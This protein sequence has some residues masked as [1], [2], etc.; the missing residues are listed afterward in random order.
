MV[1]ALKALHDIH[2]PPPIRLG[3]P[4]APGIIFLLCLFSIIILCLC[5]R[6]YGRKA[7]QFKKAA[8]QQLSAIQS[9]HQCGEETHQTAAKISLLL[10]QVA[11]LFYPRSEVASLEGEAWLSFLSKTSQKLDFNTVRD[12]L[13]HLAYNHQRDSF[14]DLSQLFTL[15][16]QWIKQRS[17]TCLN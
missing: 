10:R 2:M 13:L 16:G 9:A 4:P 11:L 12:A 7:K 15:T 3:W 1:E 5:I 14:E 6:L 8:L 17:N